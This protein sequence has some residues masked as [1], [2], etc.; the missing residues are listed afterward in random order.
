MGRKWKFELAAAM[1][2]GRTGRSQD[3]EL[4]RLEA[5]SVHDAVIYY[6]AACRPRIC[7]CCEKSEVQVP[8]PI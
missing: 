4:L 1:R 5:G 7:A 2:S 8:S 3:P 6:M